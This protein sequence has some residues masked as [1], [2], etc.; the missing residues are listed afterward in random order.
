MYRAAGLYGLIIGPLSARSCARLYGSAAAAQCAGDRA[1]AAILGGAWWTWLAV[2]GVA[3]LVVGVV[4]GRRRVPFGHGRSVAVVLV[5]L[6]APWAVAAYATGYGLARLAAG[7]RRAPAPVILAESRPR[8]D[9]AGV[10]DALVDAPDPLAALDA[11]AASGFGAAGGHV[12]WAPEDGR[13]LS[14]RPRGGLLV[15]GPPGSGKTSAVIIPSVIVAPGAC[16]ASSIKDE[17][18]AATAAIRALRGRVWHFDPGGDVAPAAGVTAARWSPLA[19]VRSWDDARRAAS[20]MAE[21]A[22]GSDDQVHW[23]DRARDW[24][25]VLLYAG[26]LAGEPIGAV[27]GWAADAAGDDTA[28]TV[29]AVLI[30]ADAA[31][32]AGA[33]IARRQL[34]GLLAAPERERG[35]VLSTMARLRSTPVPPPVRTSRSASA[36]PPSSATSW[37]RSATTTSSPRCRP[38]TATGYARRGTTRWTPGGSA[39]DRHRAQ[40]R[41][42]DPDARDAGPPP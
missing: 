4:E 41:T 9:P 40:P 38:S 16:V 21:P 1:A 7:R 24:L 19:G 20:R 12:G 2:T 22:R 14:A 18:M 17:V 29:L 15:I 26:H 37:R 33:G 10:T 35:S 11:I 27:A 23:V 8:I 42:G 34:E 5:T 6:F 36:W 30:T 3:G 31:G 32:D 39:A 13:Y 25:E 28:Q